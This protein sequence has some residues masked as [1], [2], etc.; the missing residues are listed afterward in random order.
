[1]KILIIDDNL[2]DREAIAFFLKSNGYEDILVASSGKEGIEKAIDGRPD[3]VILDVVLPDVK[4]YGI[5]KA[6]KECPE[7]NCKII[8]ITGEYHQN[9]PVSASHAAPDYFL[10]KTNFYNSLLRILKSIKK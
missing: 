8:L 1:M 9:D 4:G 2:H 7:L 6:I 3:V 10:A 5:C